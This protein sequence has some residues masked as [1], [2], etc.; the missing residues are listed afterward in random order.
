VARWSLRL[1]PVQENLTWKVRT[2]LLVL[3]TAVG[4]VLLIACVNLASLLYGVTPTDPITFIGVPAVLAGVALAA[5]W[6]PA[7]RATKVDPI[8][9]LRY[10]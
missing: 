5:C 9:A 4:F 6:I 7:W 1:E 8:H 2:T 3:L 10:E